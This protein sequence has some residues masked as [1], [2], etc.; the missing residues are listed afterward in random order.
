MLMRGEGPRWRCE[1]ERRKHRS[2]SFVAQTYELSHKV[3]VWLLGTFG[4]HPLFARLDAQILYCVWR[5]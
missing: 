5:P 1:V 2:E 4:G 3:P